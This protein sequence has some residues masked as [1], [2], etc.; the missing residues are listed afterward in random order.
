[1]LRIIVDLVKV[2]NDLVPRRIAHIL[3]DD[4][5]R[6]MLVDPLQHPPERPA[7]L[8]IGVDL[9]LLVVEVRVI[10]TRRSSDEDLEVS[11]KKGHV[12]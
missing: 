12:S 5:G 6:L 10:Y 1:M 4:N 8:S 7:G 2:L 11:R 9:L 3:K